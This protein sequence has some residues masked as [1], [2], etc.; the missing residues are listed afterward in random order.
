M[1]E[2][3]SRRALRNGGIVRIL[4]RGGFAPVGRFLELLHR[5]SGAVRVRAEV[6]GPVAEY[7][8]SGDEMYVRAK[9]ISSK[10]KENPYREGEVET[11]WTQPFTGEL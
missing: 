2:S 7:R 10:L 5:R 3:G 11:A 8:L 9:V 1:P 6:A 4:D